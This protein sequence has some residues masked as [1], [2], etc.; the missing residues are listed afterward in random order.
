[1]NQNHSS[2]RLVFIYVRIVNRKTASSALS[3]LFD[4]QEGHLAFKKN[5]VV[6]CWHDI[7]LDQGADLHKAQLMPLPLTVSCFSKI[8][9]GFIF[10]VP[11]HLGSPRKRAVK[12]VC[13]CVC[14]LLVRWFFLKDLEWLFLLHHDLL[15]LMPWRQWRSPR[16]PA[17]PLINNAPPSGSVPC[18][19]RGLTQYHILGCT[20]LTSIVYS[21]LWSSF[22]PSALCVSM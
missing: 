21:L 1:M 3:L 11:A 22:S 8:Q 7:C 17:A 15:N 5:W 6:G 18:K 12:C 2:T 14:V 20:V 4:W 19:F 9:I 16:A 10:F 13:V